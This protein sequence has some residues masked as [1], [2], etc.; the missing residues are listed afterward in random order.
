[1]VLDADSRLGLKEQS[2]AVSADANQSAAYRFDL[3]VPANANPGTYPVKVMLQSGTGN[4]AAAGAR[5]RL[6]S[7][8]TVTSIDPATLPGGARGVAVTLFD[9]QGKGVTGALDVELTNVPDTHQRVAVSLAAGATQRVVIRYPN[10]DIPAWKVCQVQATVAAGSGY[11]FTKAEPI[12]FLAAKRLANPATMDGN[13][14]KWASIPAVRVAGKEMVIRSPEFFTE[15]FA[16]QFRYA[17]DDRALYVT[18][19]VDDK[20]FYQPYVVLDVW[21]GDC[22]QLAFNLDPRKNE[23]ETANLLDTNISRRA[24][25]VNVALTKQGPEAYRSVT[26]DQATL[27]LARLSSD[28]AQMAIKQV[29]GRLIYELAFPWKSLGADAP[30]KEGDLIGVAAAVNNSNSAEQKD[31]TALGLF[32]GIV[33]TKESEKFGLLLLDK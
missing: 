12:N 15:G 22:L 26:F 8:V 13:L 6:A 27:P 30:P 2:L 32:G 23:A 3:A 33:P 17:W 31:P 1:M 21:K 16:A 9:E 24:T 10:L 29:N 11:K 14:A 25:E 18:A 20:T 28:Q 7:P 4:L 19:E 5:V